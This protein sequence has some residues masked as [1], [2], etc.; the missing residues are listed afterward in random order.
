MRSKTPLPKKEELAPAWHL[1]DADGLVLGRL[2]ARVA[3]ILMGK[4][5][6]IYTPHMDTGDF[7]L[8]VNAERVAVT[9]K[10]RQ[11]RIFYRHT[12]Y[13][14]GLKQASLGNLL[15]KKPAEVIRTAVRRMMPK[16]SLGRKML[17]KLKVYK[18][19]DHPHAAQTPKPL[20]LG[21]GRKK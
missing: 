13:P 6:P 14:G 12:G 5:K 3:R 2:A 15:E 20:D 1:I 18:G 4:H 11:S 9:G 21:L 10:K 17:K 16:T 7:V 8:I 19:P